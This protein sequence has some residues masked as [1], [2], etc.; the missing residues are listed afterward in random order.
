MSK[1]NIWIK[2]DQFLRYDSGLFGMK[3]HQ[4]HFLGWLM[5]CT[6]YSLKF[7]DIKNSK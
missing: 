2:W 6:F 1:T 3:N 7:A 4:K 5:L